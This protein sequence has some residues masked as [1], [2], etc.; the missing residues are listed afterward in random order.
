MQTLTRVDGR[1]NKSG[2]INFFDIN[3]LPGLNYPISA[4]VGQCF[5][6]FPNYDQEYVFKCLIH[7][8]IMDSLLRYNMSVPNVL[9]DHNLFKL[10]SESVLIMEE[11]MS[12][13]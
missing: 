8:V 1:L 4:L 13:I 5:I 2:A 9:Q 11:A 12:R 7:T 3:G 10:N 6:H